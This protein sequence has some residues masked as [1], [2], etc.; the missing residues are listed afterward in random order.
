M[1]KANNILN[2]GKFEIKL[3]E[4][5]SDRKKLKVQCRREKNWKMQF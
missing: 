2:Q 1:Y 4:F 5:Y 3:F